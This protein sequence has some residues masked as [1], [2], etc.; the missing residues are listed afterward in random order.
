MIRV[1]ING[2]GRIGRLTLRQL[3][4]KEGIEVVAVN[5][6]SNPETLA[7]LFKYDSAQ[8]TF[9][10]EVAHGPDALIINQKVVEVFAEKDPSSLPWKRLGIDVVV[11]CTGV[12]RDEAGAAKHLT[13]GAGKVVISAPA[14]GDGVKTVVYGINHEQLGAGDKIIS[15]ASCTTNC[16]APVAQILDEHFGIEKGYIHTIH[17]YTG[18]QNL[19]DGPHKDLRRGRAAALNIVPTTTGAARAV[20]LV[21]PRLKGKLDGMASRVPVITGSLTDL[22][23][24]LQREVTA[25]EVNS[26]V[27]KASEEKFKGILQFTTDPIVS[28]D[29]I[30]NTHSSVFDA[31]LTSASGNLVKVVSWYDNEMGY[32]ARTAD[33]VAWLA[34]HH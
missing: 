17:A 16:L 27:R 20:S 31:A 15:N 4:E 10:G 33:L 2:F 28:S 12:F 25:D 29:V 9:S 23:V 21:L 26:A 3:L 14:K 13:A 1:A 18:D 6:L 30:G 11:E 34:S 5:D 24:I 19:Q 7:H 22:T 8:G 32:A